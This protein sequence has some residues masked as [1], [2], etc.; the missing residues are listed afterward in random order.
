MTA[1]S[2]FA[3]FFRRKLIKLFVF[4][5]EVLRH[6]LFRIREKTFF[7]QHRVIFY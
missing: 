7:L 3:F 1:D 4:I 5:L 6:I 2:G